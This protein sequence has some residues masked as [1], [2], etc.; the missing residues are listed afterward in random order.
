MSIIIADDAT[1]SEITITPEAKVIYKQNFAV[2]IV[3]LS[4]FVYFIKLFNLWILNKYQ[5]VYILKEKKISLKKKEKT[6][7]IYFLIFGII[8]ELQS[9]QNAHPK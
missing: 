9:I 1:I 2:T 8:V 5:I 4:F 3:R 6:Y 7:I